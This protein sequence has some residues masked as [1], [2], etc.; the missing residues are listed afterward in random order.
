MISITGAAGTVDLTLTTLGTGDP[1]EVV[2]DRADTAEVVAGKIVAVLLA[3]DPTSTAVAVGSQLRDSEALAFSLTPERFGVLEVQIPANPFAI[4]GQSLTLTNAIGT[5]STINLASVQDVEFSVGFQSINV[6]AV[7]PGS[8]DGVTIQFRDIAGLGNNPAFA[9]FSNALRQITVFYNSAAATV[10]NRDF[11]AIVAAIDALPGFTASLTAGIGTFAFTPPAITP[12]FPIDEVYILA[13]DT[14]ATIAAKLAAH[15]NGLDQGFTASSNND[16]LTVLGVGARILGANFTEIAFNQ[17]GHDSQL[18]PSGN[19]PIFY[20]WDMTAAEV[21]EAIRTALVNGLG[22]RNAASGVTAASIEHYPGYATNRIRVFEQSLLTNTST[23][24]FSTFLP[25]DEFGAFASSFVTGSQINPRPGINNNIEGVYIDDIIIGFAERGELVTNAPTGNT[26]FVTDPQFA[27]TSIAEYPNEILVGGYTLEIRQSPDYAVPN[28][29]NSTRRPPNPRSGPGLPNRRDEQFGLG[30]SFD[31]NDRMDEGVTLIAPSAAEIEDGDTFVISN[32]TRQLVFEFD[33]NGS[34]TAGRVRVPFQKDLPDGRPFPAHD[35]ATSMRDAINSTQS[36]NVLGIVA[37]GVDGAETG[38]ST[39]TRIN[40]FGPTVFVNPSG[41]QFIKVDLVAAETKYGR[42]TARTLPTVDQENRQATNDTIGTAE[43]LGLANP[44]NTSYRNGATDTLIAVGKVGDA[45]YT[46]YTNSI[47]NESVFDFGGY[48][49]VDDVDAVRIFL[50][51]GDR[52]DAFAQVVGLNLGSVLTPLVRIFDAETM[53]L[54]ATGI[55]GVT[56]YVAPR[57]GFYVVAV[58]SAGGFGEYQLTIRPTSRPASPR[59]TDAV[60]PRYFLESGDSNVAR[61]QGQLI[62]EANFISDFAQT[63]IRA[64]YSGGVIPGVGTGSTLAQHPGGV[65]LLRNPNTERLVPGT[66]IVNNVITATQGSGIVFSGIT[67]TSGS[68][69]APVPFGRIV[70]NTVVGSGAGVGITV[71]NSTSP[72]VLNNVISGFGTGLS[73]DAS[74]ISTVEN[75]NAF[76]NTTTASTRPLAPQSFE[77]PDGVSLFEDPGRRLYIPAEGSSVIDSS[78]SNLND[79]ATFF[80]TVKQPVGIS[81]SP[82]L[83]PTFDAYGIP[84]VDDP[85]VT[86]PG[87]IGGNVFID[88]GG[89]DRSDAVQPTA[90]LVSPVD[91]IQGQGVQVAFGD[92]DPDASFVR[93]PEGSGPVTFFEIQL[94]DPAGT[95]PDASTINQNTVILTENG[96]T[97]IPGVDYTFG[98]SDNRRLIRLTPLSGL[99][100]PDAVYEITLNNRDRVSLTLPRGEMIT[101]GEQYIVTDDQGRQSVF[102]FDSGFV[103]QVPQTLAIE[104]LGPNTFFNDGDVFTVVSPSGELRNFEIN[105][106]GAVASGNIPI[107]LASAGT[108]TEIRDVIL[109]ALAS[110]DGTLD[111]APTALGT[112][113]LQIGSL[114]GHTLTGTVAGLRFFGTGGGVAVGDQFRYQAGDNSVTFEFTDGIAPVDPDS[115]AITIQRTDT[116]DQIADK[117]AGAVA[118]QSLGLAAARAIGDGRVVLGGTPDDQLDASDSALVV[119]GVPGVTGPLQ[120]RVSALATPAGLENATFAIQNGDV[121]VSFVLTTDPAL[122]TPNRRVVMSPTAT[123]AQIADAI[124]AEIT[125][126]FSGAL[127][128]TANGRFV[129]LNEQPSIIPAGTAQVRATIS[130]TTP[131][132]GSLGVSGGAIAVPFIPTRMFS[133]A[134]AA[135]A[136]TTAIATSPLQVTTFT[137][138]G[139]TLLFGNTL[140]IER[141]TPGGAISTAGIPLPAVTDLAGNPVESNRDNDET[142]FTITMPEVRFDFGDAP[143]TYGTLLANNGARHSVG[144]N[145]LPRLGRVVDTET[146]GQPFPAT[147]DVVIPVTVTSPSGSALFGISTLPPVG[148]QITISTTVVPTSGDRIRVAVGSDAATFELVAPG[149][150]SLTGNIPVSLLPTDTPMTIAA[151]LAAAITGE[152]APTGRAVEVEVDPIDP[153]IS[154][155]TLDDEDGVALGQITVGVQSYFVFLDPSADQTAPTPN[156]VLGFLN[157]LD[158]SGTSVAVTVSGAGLLDAWVDFNGD[159]AFDPSREQVLQNRAV[160]DGV[161]IL[162]IATP[163]NAV[164]GTTW[165]RF[166]LSTTG[167]LRPTGSAVGGEV[168]DYRISIIPVAPFQPVNDNYSTLEDVP[169]V[170][171]PI[172]PDPTLLDNDLNLISPFLPPRVVIVDQPA[173]GTVTV[174]DP[175]TGS[176]DYVPN[177][178]FNGIDTFT[179]RLSSEG[180]A[181]GASP[182]AMIATVTITVGAVNDPPVVDVLSPID[183]LERDDAAV[184][185]VPGVITNALPGRPEATDE[186]ASQTV[187][188]TI[189]SAASTIPVDLF[190]T[191]PVIVPILDGD[192]FVV[193][194]DLQFV[195]RRDAFGTALIVI[196]TRDNHPTDPQSTAVTVT[197]NIRP[198]NDAPALNPATLGIT[199]NQGPDNVYQ[200]SD[201]SDPAAAAGTITYTSAEDRV[202]FIP[203]RRPTGVFGFNRIGLLDVFTVGPSNETLAV[204]GGNQTLELLDIPTRT[205]AGGTLTPV[206]VSGQVTGFNYL[207]PQDFNSDFGGLDSFAYSVIDDNP[208]GGE[209]WDLAAGGLIDDQL[210]TQGFVQLR[211]N[212][213]ND[214]PQF[215]MSTN[216]ISVLEDSGAFRLNG[217]AFNIFAGPPDTAIDETDPV[218][219]QRVTF[220]VAGLTPPTLQLFAVAPTVSPT[221]V[222]TFTPAPNA[223]GTAVLEVRATD[224]GPDNAI[225][226]DEV[227][228]LAQTLTINIRP[229]NDRPEL[230]TTTPIVYTLNEDSAILQPNNS[231]SFQGVFIP[232][233]GSGGNVGLLD[234]FNP[235]PANESSN[236]TPGGNQ[237]LR[238]TTPVPASTAQ[239]GTLSRVFDPQN[240]S[241]LIGLRYTPRANF[242]GTDSF[243]YGVVDNGVSTDLDGVPF[244]DFREA[245][246]TVTLNVLALNDPPQFSGPLSV[247]VDEDAT[248]TSIIGQSIIPNFVTDIAAGPPG[249]V[250]E[251]HPVTG[252]TVSF[253][254]TPAPGNPAN[255]FAAAPAVSSDGTLTFQTVQ[256]ANG[257]A[258]F[259]IFARDNGPN[260]PPLEVNTSSPPRTFTI[261]VNPIND[262]PTFVPVL[263]EIEVLEDSGPFTTSVPFATQISPGPAD[264]VAAG[265]TVRFEVTVPTA[266]QALFQ[267]QPTV[268]D[269]GFFRFTPRDNAVGSTVV[270]VVAVDSEGARSTP[271]TVTI[272][273]VEVNDAPEAG[274]LSFNSDE[275]SLFTVPLQDVMAVAIDPDLETNPNE[276]LS[277]TA[278]SS[279]SQNGAIVTVLPSGDILYDPTQAPLIQALRPGQILPDTFTYRL[280]DAAGELS[281]VATVTINVAGLND[282]PTVQDD[283]ET[284]PLSGSATIRPLDND[285]DVDGTIDPSSIEITLLPAFGSVEVRGDGTIIYSPFANFRGSD[286]IRYTVAD[287]L[288][289]RSEQATITIDMNLPPVAVNDL[290]NTFR[291]RAVEI[292]VAANDSDPDGTLDLNSI[293]IVTPPARGTAIVLGGGIVR[294]LPGSDFVGIETFTYTIRDTRGRPSNVGQVRIQVVASELQNPSNFTDVDASGE[295]SPIDALLIL[296]RLSQ[297]NR[298]GNSGGMPI[299]AALG[300]SPIRFYDVDGSRLIEPIDALAVI[301][302]VARQNRLALEGEGEQVTAGNSPSD[303]GLAAPPFMPLAGNTAPTTRVDDFASVYGPVFASNDNGGLAA[304]FTLPEDDVINTLAID[305]AK[306]KAEKRRS[307]LLEAID[308]A[309]T[310]AADF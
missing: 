35:V 250:D 164:P 40:L 241:V 128:A 5:T 151:K 278:V 285:F 268:T 220:S 183:L 134:S 238:L 121:L 236:I 175:L 15:I 291:D 212:P 309:W 83:A 118:T 37:A 286:T 171:T 283:F 303:P 154:I 288:G 162:N 63:G 295:T 93:L 251:L 18:L 265:Q 45:V 144:A 46:D 247:T 126:G 308:A 136:L 163:S 306:E 195:Q 246:N 200:V 72:T 269:N 75:G 189:D 47:F 244:N 89:I 115:I 191:P 34:V 6:A 12:V 53:G 59:Q 50:N 51:V 85:T 138:G 42:E 101:D 148:A 14:P 95:G 190:Q 274:N 240:P 32:G 209:T 221:G 25:G 41:G 224:N 261:T 79:R 259:T 260:N 203:L 169:L 188:I 86:T 159:G 232:L 229:V 124:A 105:L 287:N 262:P 67:P 149:V 137:P 174:T 298:E 204:D 152:L 239:G 29:F 43:D 166:R 248:T 180:D 160:V 108:V 123:P 107:N 13:T 214:R 226:G 92:N 253:V 161:N 52:I 73:I 64:T 218:T 281:N 9:N 70:N 129:T 109:T 7:T 127:P 217:L 56:G 31:T 270:T 184:V 122:V 65:A 91:F 104:V 219:G 11:N 96:I 132:L 71:S 255:L 292:D 273:L 114:F 272:T 147:D 131:L 36:R 304:D 263:T 177:T 20:H 310:D 225:R 222:L 264:E 201:G 186:L 26:N 143:N 33:T 170:V 252:Q 81:A 165:I 69:P 94:L 44:V 16:Q 38:P 178:A 100:R 243:I 202:L 205:S 193:G 176:F 194:A 76:Q 17:G 48:R 19:V 198:V 30:R 258:V 49:P 116:V 223:F 300:E 57:S 197:L 74:S 58:S 98:Y 106:S 82:I 294:Y 266:G 299:E 27:R 125:A 111:L 187:A 90:V 275:D 60:I 23:L 61:A 39:T 88:R 237:T 54:E 155:Q 289:A 256:D 168:E 293:E 87:G 103:M 4:D 77:I 156:D 210:V 140:L 254:I 290:A 139:G 62:I 206:V 233:N 99:W 228:S 172:S 68:S 102:E 199:D 307:E 284:L 276:F 242:N 257:V 207:P 1:N 141:R 173:N 282:A 215:Q 245:F 196:N 297:W 305:S 80:N 158:P 55:D 185:T 120:L 130:T 280:I 157:P 279:V 216:S 302:E 97:L 249:A 192:G 296:N 271:A 301:I 3:L 277:L 208:L 146:N 227:S 110:V 135:A 2:F 119:V 182:N 78:F 133:P 145:A 230:N 142:R 153:V 117:I 234:V 10:T 28:D 84:R 231:V 267:A 22:T 150:A 181:R 66:V 179:Y 167:N 211:I 113:S 8:A 112:E 235:G 213:V 24:G 21:R